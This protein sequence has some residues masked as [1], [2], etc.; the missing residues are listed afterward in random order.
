M[1]VNMNVSDD[2]IGIL[3]T[4]LEMLSDRPFDLPEKVTKHAIRY[5]AKKSVICSNKEKLIF[6]IVDT[7]LKWQQIKQLRLD[8]YRRDVPYM[9]E[10]LNEDG[11]DSYD[12]H[13]VV[14]GC[15]YE[16]KAVA[17]IRFTA[18]PFEIQNFI[19]YETNRKIFLDNRISNTLEFS[20]LVVD[21]NPELQK[22][23]PGLLIYTGLT[24]CLF[25]KYEY[26][27]GFTKSYV[28][29]KLNKFMIS[30]LNDNFVIPARG[31][32]TYRVL[33]GSFRDDY[34][35]LIDQVVKPNFL[36]NRLKKIYKTS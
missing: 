5:L 30:S 19:S 32:H 8:V 33:Q 28:Y 7:P 13:S 6:S 1:D 2:L 10:V 35:H 3:P 12:S 11:T 29:E 22:I 4:S 9:C 25:T 26:Y 14:F 17:T 21:K 27:V 15:W 16:G 31:D 20:R 18:A 23:L 24:I 34:E 36:A